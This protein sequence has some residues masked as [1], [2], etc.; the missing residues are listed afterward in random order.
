MDVL[1]RLTDEE[2]VKRYALGDSKAF[3][4]LLFRHQSKVF[5]YIY[6]FVRD[7]ELTEDIFQDTFMKAIVTIQQGKYVESGK[8]LSWLNRIAHNLIVDYFRRER[9]EN[10]F[11]VSTAGYDIMNDAQLAEKC[12]EDVMSNEQVLQDVAHLVTFLP[13]VQR[14]VVRMR[15]FEELSFK[16]IADR[17]GV[18]INTALGRMRYALIN[19]RR[20]AVE[21]NIH[22]ELK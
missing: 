8:F 17:T 14:E 4:E 21:C 12:V 15:Y 10:T 16:E 7:R 5:A 1:T 9:N 2:L 13:D 6:L 20:M 19:M 18:S 3:E 11:P 22:L